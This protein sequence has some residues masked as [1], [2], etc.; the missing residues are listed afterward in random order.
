RADQAAAREGLPDGDRRL[1][2][3]A[4]C[5]ILMKHKKA[6][7]RSACGSSA[8]RKSLR[9]IISALF[10]ASSVSGYGR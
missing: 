2:A 9:N 4:V 6:A 10:A 7:A 5:G 1:P 8:C 3:A